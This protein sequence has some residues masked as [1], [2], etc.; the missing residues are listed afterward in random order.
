[1]LGRYRQG[2]RSRESVTFV[3]DVVVG[4]IGNESHQVGVG[5]AIWAAAY[6]FEHLRLAG[7]FTRDSAVRAK[8]H[9]KL[10]GAL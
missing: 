3:E 2:H 8:R 5:D 10:T 9:D 7:L 6:A 1:M 4:K